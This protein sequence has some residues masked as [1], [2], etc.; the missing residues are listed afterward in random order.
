[1]SETNKKAW[2]V[3]VN[4]GYG[5]QRTA[6]PLKSLA[7]GGEIIQANDYPG[8][9]EKDRKMWKGARM[10]YEAVSRF[11][12]VPLAGEFTFSLF[13]QF[14]KIFSF[15]PKRDSSKPNF[16]L[17]Q[18]FLLIKKGW[19]KDLIEKCKMRG[20][21]LPFI[22]TFFTPAFMAESFDYPGDI[23]CVVC[24]ADIARTWA[25]LNPRES[26]I[27]YFAPNVRVVERLKLYGV[28][29]S[30]IFLT[31]YP[32]PSELTGGE[33][34]GILKENLRTRLLNLDPKGRYCRYYQALIEEH[35]GE[36]PRES[37]RP[38]TIMF[39]VGGAGAQKEIGVKIVKALAQ[40]IK[41]GRVR[42]ILVAGSKRK[43][44]EYF[45]EHTRGLDVEIVFGEK[46]EDYFQ[47]FNLALG[48]TDVL[49]TKPSELSFYS[50]L[51]LPII[52]APPIGSQEEFNKRWLLK[53]GFGLSQENSSH[54]RQWLFDWV[55]HGYLAEA[56][57]QG[58]IEGEKL[59][60]F[61]IKKICLG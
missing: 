43:I 36:M 22:S 23:F 9:P 10:F 49:W 12:R 51:G 61:K 25:P 19:G 27:K 37:G 8:I 60:T 45:K 16:Q 47:S 18:I 6:Y 14:Q 17:K 38:L 4:M 13:D 57:I 26:R 53:S 48:K 24:D 41:N 28:K 3:S 33:D 29:E 39:A 56:A 15:Y 35:L 55:E 2:I 34:L 50:A 5:H 11:K 20:G 30:N 7:Y 21:G 46:V 42:I 32:L 1:M 54:L 31:G 52:V 59:G 40:E 58:F 44:R